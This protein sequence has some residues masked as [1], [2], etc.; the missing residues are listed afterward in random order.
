MVSIPT[1]FSFVL[2]LSHFLFYVCPSHSSCLAPAQSSPSIHTYARFL[3]LVETCMSH[4]SCSKIDSVFSLLLPPPCLLNCP[5]RLHCLHCLGLITVVQAALLVLFSPSLSILYSFCL[6]RYTDYD[7]RLAS[8]T[9]SATL[10]FLPLSPS[11]PVLPA[12]TVSSLIIL[13]SPAPS[14]FYNCTGQRQN[15]V[16][17]CNKT[18]NKKKEE[19]WLS[20]LS[21]ASLL[22]G[23]LVSLLVIVSYP[24]SSLP[25]LSR[26]R[27]FLASCPVFC[28]PVSQSYI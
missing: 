6:T 25:P 16:S 1:S 24:S 28:L 8:I 15:K 18:S 9:T 5:N 19:S 13:Y 4:D 21:C 17:K 20:H 11:C 14:A 2:L 23:R 3:S 10:V 22:S 26:H 7:D 27:P 12:V